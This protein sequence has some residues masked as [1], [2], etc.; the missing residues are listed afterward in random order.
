MADWYV[1]SVVWNALPQFAASHAYSVGDIV[2]PLTAPTFNNQFAF[3]CTTA[4][5]S[6]TEPAWP[7]VNNSTVTTGGATFTNVTGQSTYGWAAAAGNL[8]ELCYQNVSP[9]VLPG[10]RAFLS[11]DHSETN[12]LNVYYAHG[13][14]QFGSVATVSV[15]RAGSVPP[16]TADAQSGAT[17]IAAAGELRLDPLINQYWQGIT[18][19]LASGGAQIFLAF[20][21]F[22]RNYFKNCSIV[23]AAGSSSTA[24][25]GT[26]D[27]ASAVFDNTTVTFS[28][29]GQRFLTLYPFDFTWINT[30]SAVLGTVP[31]TL[32]QGNN[33]SQP[34][35]T[36]TCRGVDLSAITN[37]LYYGMG[38]SASY[39]KLLF[40]SCRIA[41]GVVRLGTTAYTNAG[42]EVELVNCFDGTNIISERHT[43]AGDV[44]TEFT[45]T[46][47]GGAQDNVGTYSHKMVSSSRSDKYVMTLDG[48]WIDLNVATIGGARTATVEIIGSVAL[49]NDEIS[50]WIEY[51]GIAGSSRASFATG[52]A[53]LSPASVP[54]STATW[55]SLPATPVAQ[56]L[57]VVFTPLTI[58]RVR[59]QVRLGRPSTTVYYNPQVTIS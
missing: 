30:P 24:Y 36:I 8:W 7:N 29:A 13:G 40:D 33:A 25:I 48:F 19:T 51:Q 27:P 10:D 39:T 3:R 16:T 18:F 17:I 12:S 42:D 11:S 2:R 32:F 55:L 23:F 59:A 44:T 43:P 58:G 41:P 37:T 52:L 57:Q 15:N 38:S 47:A 26:D 45:I 49:N 54:T 1:S 46:L 50:L 34:T 28:N 21:G 22:K 31:T 4:G 53:V 14:T 56:R 9:R 5:T 20:N 35:S 6:S